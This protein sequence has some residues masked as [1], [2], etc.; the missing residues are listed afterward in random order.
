[1]IFQRG[2]NMKIFKK[3]LIT[4]KEKTYEIRVYYND[5]IINI[6][7]FLNN[8]PAYGLRHQIQIPKK[9]NVQGIL[10]EE[11]V[12]EL[13]EMSKKD[14]IEKRGDRLTKVIQDNMTASSTNI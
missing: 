8:Y 3:A 14:I 4:V 9:C 11:I 5:T 10:R 6:A 7:P 1:M 12:D 2:I 13:V